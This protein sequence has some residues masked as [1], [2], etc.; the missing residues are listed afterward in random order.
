MSSILLDQGVWRI[1]VGSWVS[2]QGL[3]RGYVLGGMIITEESSGFPWPTTETWLDTMT[4]YDFVKEWR[5][6]P[7]PSEVGKTVDGGLIALDR[8]GEDGVLLFLGGEQKDGVGVLSRRSL[9]TVWVYGIKTSA[10]HEQI[11]TGDIPVGRRHG[12][13]F[14]VPAPDL[15]RYQIYTFSGLPAGD[16]ILLDLYGNGDERNRYQVTTKAGIRNL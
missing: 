8:V 9:D 2:N 12:C 4:Q 13:Y 7:L 16:V 14:T 11:T 5:T 3:R 6:E 1:S 15:S 10:W